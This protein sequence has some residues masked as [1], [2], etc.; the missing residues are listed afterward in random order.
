GVCHDSKGNV[1]AAAGGFAALDGFSTTGMILLPMSDLVPAST[2]TPA[3]VQVTSNTYITEPIEVTQQGLSPV[4]ALQPAGATAG[5]PSSVFT[6][7]PLKD[8]T[9][10]AVVVSDGVLDKTGKLIGPGTVAQ[11][12]RFT[13]PISVGGKSQLVGIDDQTA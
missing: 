9:D 6:T 7:R 4:I 2:V 8:N 3:N 10:Y 12:L 11:I 13:N 1:N 5:N